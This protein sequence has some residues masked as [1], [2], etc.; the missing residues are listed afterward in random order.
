MAVRNDD[1]T[2]ITRNGAAVADNFFGQS[3]FGSLAIANQRNVLKLADDA[4]SPPLLRLA[5]ASR[6]GSGDPSFAAGKG[7]RKL[8]GDWRR[9]GRIVGRD[10]REDC[11][12]QHNRGGR[13]AGIAAIDRA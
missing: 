13:A 2:R 11:R 5:A 12:M 3:S 8:G 9:G 1:M 10:R 7:R 4:D 6:P